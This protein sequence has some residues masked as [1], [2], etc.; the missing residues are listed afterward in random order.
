MDIRK[1]SATSNIIRVALKN[2]STGAPLTGLTHS[3]SGLIISTITDVE[4]SAT[5]YTQAASN[6]ETITTNG[7]F[8]A[9][10]SSKCRFKEVDSTNHPGLYEIQI[11]DARFSVSNAKKLYV[12][13]SGATNLLA[14]DYLIGLVS[15]DPFD[16]VRMGMTALPNAA[17]EAAGG[18]YTRGTGAG[19]INQ[20]ANGQID[21]RTVTMATDVI[22][23]AAL[24]TDAGTEIGTAV[25]ASGTRILTA[26]DEDT[27]TLDL[28]ATIRAA[29]GMSS[30]NL[31]AQ[32]S[33]IDDFL[34]T[35]VA[36]I[37]AKTDQLTFTTAS[38]VD[39][40]VFGIENNAITAGAI[41][42]DAIGSNELAATATAEIAAAVWDEV[43]TGATHN[44]TNSAG[45]RLRT[46]QDTGNY[47]NGRVWLDTNGANTGST[48]PDDGTFL[49]PV[50]TLARALTVAA[51]A[52]QPIKRLWVLGGSSITLASAYSSWNID[53]DGYGLALGGQNISNSIFQHF[54]LMTGTATAPSGFPVFDTGALGA[55]TLPPCIVINAGIT[56]TVTI[57]SAGDFLFIGCH[58]QTSGAVA[59]VLDMAAIGATNVKF[60]Q[61]SGGMTI[62][63]M[64]AG[65][66]VSINAISGGGV[67]VNGT[68]GT[69]IVSGNI[70]VTDNSGGAVTISQNSAVNMT[71]INA[72]VDTAILDAALVSKLDAIADYIDTE[73]AAIKAKTDNLPSDPADASVIAARFDALDTSIGDIP[74]ANENA[75]AL[76][77]RADAIETGLTLRKILRGFGAALL[78][79]VSG[80]A[81]STVIFR[82]VND[83][84]DVITATVDANG[85]RTA[86]T[87]DLT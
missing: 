40:Q 5:T 83:T 45:R 72:E 51:A 37:K 32:L 49:N 23:A 34:D 58:S 75:D 16:A 43:L 11:A 14:S 82:D 47:M 66:F 78:G 29:V 84:K 69:V 52:T 19:Q 24:A 54:G 55:V 65:D 73:V 36:A 67:T 22:T 42:T 25:W 35:E 87:T 13:I 10:T 7:T 70:S 20:N 56:D 15:Y 81:T 48:F 27:T 76:L 6:I 9:P 77:D 57:G 46:L 12:S 86:I 17:A 38:R 3:S 61:W 30:A 85:N 64:A 59:P 1:H 74:T 80:A 63:N 68:G 62:N 26:L 79:K 41:A 28:D 50:N 60:R 18:L 31:D 21:T 71:K 2:S 33:T 8:A 39:V 4:S 53:G 44:I